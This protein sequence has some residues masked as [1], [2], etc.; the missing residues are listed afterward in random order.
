M[1]AMTV[2]LAR[3]LTLEEWGAMDEDDEGEL[4]EGV[5]VEEE[6]PGSLHEVVVCWLTRILGDWLARRGGFV[7]G[8]GAKFA[9][10]PRRG[11]IPDAS[12]FLPGR[13]PPAQG[14]IHIP[15]D[16]VIEVVSPSPR[17]E[18]RDRI[19][20]LADYA[21]FGVRWY[22]L[23]DPALRSFE[24]LEL[25]AQ[26]RYAHACAATD[27]SLERIP[28]FDGLTLDVPALWAEIDRLEKEEE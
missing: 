22:W 16:V 25:D 6:M 20:K 9:V 13:K 14:I 24:I 5:L 26:G 10:R 7:L 3:S 15:P 21:A 19:D 2:T 4:V 27:A 1:S 11:R 8:S 28:G 12:V 23:V 18:R 17:D